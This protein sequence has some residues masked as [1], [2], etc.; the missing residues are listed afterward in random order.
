MG[1]RLVDRGAVDLVLQIPTIALH[2]VVGDDQGAERLA[3]RHAALPSRAAGA[4][5]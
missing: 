3:V 1:H 2:I 5:G 4:A